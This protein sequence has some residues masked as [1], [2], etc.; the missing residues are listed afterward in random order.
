[1]RITWQNSIEVP[2][3][4]D[5]VYAKLSDF[6]RHAEW[7]RSIERMEKVR[8]GDANG[9]G[10]RYITHERIEFPASGSKKTRTS[11]MRTL[12]EVRELVPGQRIAWHAHPLPRTGS[13]ELCFELS[14]TDDGGTRITQTVREYYPLPIAFVMRA[15][16]N[17]TEDGIHKQLDRGLLT[18]K[19]TLISGATHNETTN[20]A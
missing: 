11:S 3:P 5:Q 8:D 13:A 2:A 7:A 1:M 19:E 17:I 12:C 16:Y 18:L 15:F 20:P 9:I 6:E 10:R 14:P 4:V